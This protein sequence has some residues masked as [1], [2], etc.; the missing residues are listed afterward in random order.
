VD[1]LWRA[2]LER[3]VDW[4][5]SDHACCSREQKVAPDRPEDIWPARSGF[6]ETEYLLSGVF[7]EGCRRG[8]AERRVF[9]RDFSAWCV[10]VRPG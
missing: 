9:L 3:Q 10:H 6:G 2:V 4:I 7:S 1:A 8:M 5:V